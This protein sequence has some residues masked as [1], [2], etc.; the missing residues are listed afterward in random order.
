[1]QQHASHHPPEDVAG[2]W[3]AVRAS[4][5]VGVDPLVKEGQVLKFVFAE[6]ARNA[7]A[8]TGHN[9]HL[10]AQKHLLG[11]DGCQAAQEIASLSHGAPAPAALP[12]SLAVTWENVI[13]FLSGSLN[14]SNEGLD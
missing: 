12:P 7:D 10:P 9:Y 13:K 14:L 2:V 11:Y 6:I 4:G 3:E 5:Q 8:L 1:M